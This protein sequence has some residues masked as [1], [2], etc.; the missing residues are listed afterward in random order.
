MTAHIKMNRQP[1]RFKFLGAPGITIEYRGHFKLPGKAEELLKPG[2]GSLCN[3]L[4]MV[5]PILSH[6]VTGFICFRI[7]VSHVVIHKLKP[8]VIHILIHGMVKFII[9]SFG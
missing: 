3:F 8:F 4:H 5:S 1:S 2:N 6:G 9:R 7:A